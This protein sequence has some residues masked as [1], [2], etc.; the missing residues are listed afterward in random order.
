MLTFYGRSELLTVSTMSVIAKVGERFM[1]PG[2]QYHVVSEA[3][4]ALNLTEELAK[5][6][7]RSSC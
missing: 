2:C 7:H 1:D 6:P 4:D 3:E 5:V